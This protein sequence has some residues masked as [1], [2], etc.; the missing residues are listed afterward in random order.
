M[1][2]EEKEKKKGEIPEAEK[3]EEKKEAPKEEKKAGAKEV[4]AEAPKEGE[5]KRE[6]KKKKPGKLAVV[7][8][9]SSKNDTI[10]TA[11]DIS[12]AET[13]SWASGGMMVKSSREEGKPY[14]AMQAAQKVVNELKDKG[15]DTVHIKIR[16]PGGNGS[17]TP[18]GGAQAVV[19]TIARMKVRVGRIEDVTPTPTDSM[20]RAGGRRGR[21][22]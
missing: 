8:V 11:T 13:L 1:A 22:V 10:I 2:E 21:R 20:K 3:Q 5:E 15:V 6:I 19:R 18:G 14:A 9:Y 16:A 4:P 12:G 7:H 17:K